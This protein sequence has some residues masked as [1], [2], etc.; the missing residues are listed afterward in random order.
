MELSR[1]KGLPRC[2]VFPCDGPLAVWD[3]SWHGKRDPLTEGFT[4]TTE[5]FGL[6]NLPGMESQKVIWSHAKPE[7]GV[8]GK[9][10]LNTN[11]W[12]DLICPAADL[13]PRMASPGMVSWPSTQIFHRII[14]CWNYTLWHSLNF[15]LQV[16]TCGLLWSM[17]ICG[18]SV[19]RASFKRS[20]DGAT[21]PATFLSSNLGGGKKIPAASSVEHWNKLFGNHKRNQNKLWT[22]TLY[23]VGQLS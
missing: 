11:F 9:F 10:S 19:I 6:A 16:H 22:S 5:T 12:T 17:D 14:G 23:I 21:L 7:R 13:S 2:Q 3:D 1:F 15:I 18:N 8:S 20:L 4:V